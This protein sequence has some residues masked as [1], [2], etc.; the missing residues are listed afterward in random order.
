MR[1]YGTKNSPFTRIVRIVAAELGF[2]L[3]W[4]DMAWRQ[5]PDELFRINP[6][7]RVPLLFDGERRLSES[8]VICMYLMQHERA[9]PGDDFRPLAGHRRWDEEDVL[10]LGYGVIE[11]AG[12]IRAFRDP[13]AVLHPYLARCQERIARCLEAIETLSSPGFLIDPNSFGMAEIVV[14]TAVDV[15]EAAGIATVDGYEHIETIRRKFS[16]RRSLLGSA[17]KFS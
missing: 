8:R 4:C 6:G 7:G 16:G 5:S 9:C 11:S 17:P 14:L 2:E 3:D 13:P 12:L 10:N 1:I 15:I